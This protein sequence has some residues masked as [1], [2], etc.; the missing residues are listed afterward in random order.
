MSSRRRLLLVAA[1]LA[2][3]VL[4]GVGVLL[5]RPGGGSAGD[6]DGRGPLVWAGRPKVFAHDTLPHDRILRGRVKN[7]SLRELEVKASELVLRD[8]AGRRLKAA[9]VFLEAFVH[10]LLPPAGNEGD[11]P[12]AEVARLGRLAAFEPSGR[13]P[14]TVAWRD[15]PGGVGPPV[16]IEYGDGELPVPRSP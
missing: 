9:P 16:R 7:D 10:G 2:A 13:A 4:A 5:L 1:T 11:L 15:E 3:L 12:K 14:L 8:A 6:R